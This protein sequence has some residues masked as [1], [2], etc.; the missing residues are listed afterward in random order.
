MEIMLLSNIMGGTTGNQPLYL[1]GLAYLHANILTIRKN[2]N[3]IGSNNYLLDNIDRHIQNLETN[4]RASINEFG[5]AG[6]KDSLNS[7]L[8]SMDNYFRLEQDLNST[9]FDL[10]LKGAN[11]FK[12]KAIDIGKKFKEFTVELVRSITYDSRDQT[13]S[14]AK[15]YFMQSPAKTDSDLKESTDQNWDELKQSLQLIIN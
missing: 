10:N 13:I 3:N 11:A 6:N 12:T 14:D 15:D 8:A 9:K 4:K 1:S 5:K 2:L 7:L